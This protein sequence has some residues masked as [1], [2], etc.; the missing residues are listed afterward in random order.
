MDRKTERKIIVVNRQTRLDGLL[1]RHNTIEQ[2]RFYVESMNA[3]FDNYVAEDSVYKIA[4]A[5][6][7]EVLSKMGRFQLLERKAPAPLSSRPS[8]TRPF[9]DARKE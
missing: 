3:D 8:Y 5:S 4:L 9:C 1:Y 6:A 7:V 2:A